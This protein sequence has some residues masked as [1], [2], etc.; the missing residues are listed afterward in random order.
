MDLSEEEG[1][2]KTFADLRRK[3]EEMKLYDTN[4]NIGSDEDEINDTDA[5]DSEAQKTKKS[6][7]S[8]KSKGKKNSV[9]ADCS[10]E[11]VIKQFGELVVSLNAITQKLDTKITAGSVDV[12]SSSTQQLM[13]VAQ[14]EVQVANVQ[15]VSDF[16]GIGRSRFA[17][18]C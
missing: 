11:V 9:T 1:G 4:E 14:A 8:K 2:I 7:S 6:S 12:V 5:D 15:S 16:Q 13:N 17:P 10:V 3:V 18:N